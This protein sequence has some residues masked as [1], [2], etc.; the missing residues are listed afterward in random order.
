MSSRPF[1]RR[2]SFGF[3][4]LVLLF[5]GW[6]WAR[7]ISHFDRLE[8][9]LGGHFK[10]Q[11]F[12]NSSQLLFG[13]ERQPDLVFSGDIGFQTGEYHLEK[14]WFRDPVDHV[15]LR[16]NGGLAHFLSVS[17]STLVVLWIIVWGSGMRWWTKRRRASAEQHSIGPNALAEAG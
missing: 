15:K 12:S 11:A 16:I 17:Y 5:L 4:L 13:I 14:S 10:L 8:G 9:S 1:Y 6:A 2:K 3:G 7:S